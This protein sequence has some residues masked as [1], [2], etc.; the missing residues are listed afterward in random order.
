MEDE[1][2]KEEGLS[3]QR[4]AEMTGLS[5]HT[6]RYYEEAG[7]LDPVGRTA[8]GHRRYSAEE[9][10]WVRFLACLRALEMPIRSMHRYAEL[11]RE[12]PRTVAERRVLLEEYGSEVRDRIDELGRNLAAIE[13][14]IGIYREMEAKDGDDTEEA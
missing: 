10:E 11:W 12:G 3:V 1:H 5:A 7:L 14:K 4:V 2:T 9:V 13:E 8:S 6:L